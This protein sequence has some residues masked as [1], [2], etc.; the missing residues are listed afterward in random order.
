MLHIAVFRKQENNLIIKNQPIEYKPIK[1]NLNQQ[2]L[3][4]RKETLSKI[5]NYTIT[6]I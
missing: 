1:L 6:D 4:F 5:S 2:N 3:Y